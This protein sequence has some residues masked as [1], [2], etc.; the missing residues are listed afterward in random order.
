MELENEADVA[1]AEI[2]EGFPGK[3]RG[4]DGIDTN[5]TC[6]RTVEGS[7]DLQE[8]GLSGSRGAYDADNLSAVDV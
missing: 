1:V 5:G 2:G 6:V 7:D 8:R 3:G 4:V